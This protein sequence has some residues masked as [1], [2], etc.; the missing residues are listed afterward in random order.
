MEY[1]L[2]RT[3]FKPVPYGILSLLFTTYFTSLSP[4]I[5]D[6]SLRNRSVWIT[7][8]FAIATLISNPFS[9]DYQP[10]PFGLR[11]FSLGIAKPHLMD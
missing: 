10:F 7:S 11:T 1:Q 3:D 9:M 4:Q 5:L 2:F 8:P 6:L